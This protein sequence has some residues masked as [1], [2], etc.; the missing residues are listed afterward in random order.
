[1]QQCVHDFHVIFFL[2]KQQ[3]VIIDNNVAYI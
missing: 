3:R 1:M 2:I